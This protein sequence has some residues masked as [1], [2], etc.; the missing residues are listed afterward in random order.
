MRITPPNWV[1]VRQFLGILKLTFK[2]FESKKR[3]LKSREIYKQLTNVL[4][5]IATIETFNDLGEVHSELVSR[6]PLTVQLLWKLECNCCLL[7]NGFLMDIF[8]KFDMNGRNQV[9]VLILRQWGRI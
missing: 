7:S 2:F 8:I 5:T 6:Q 9:S 4:A 1:P 3:Y